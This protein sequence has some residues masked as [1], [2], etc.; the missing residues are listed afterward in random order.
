MSFLNSVLKVFVGDKAK[1]DVK[2]LQPIIDKIHSFEKELANLSNDE[3]RN[4]TLSFKAQLKNDTQVINDRIQALEVEVK[5]S[6][7][8]DKNEDIYAEIDGL[9]KE[10]YEISE[11]TL[12]SILP[13]AFAVVKETS[14]RFAN[15]TT[16]EVTASEY[17]RQLSG[18]K[19]YV[20]LEGDK[21]IWQNSWNAAGKEV[22]WD[23]VH[24]DVQL[25]GG[26]ALHEGKI[27]EMHTGEG[28]TLVAT[29][30]LYLNA[31]TGNGVH[32]VTVN[33]YLAKR[34]SA[35]M[36]PI[37][38]FHG[39][40]IECIDNHQ[41]NS[42]GRRAAYNA[43]ITYGT[44]NEFG[45][46]YLRDNMAHTPSDLVQRPHNFAIVD[47][48]DSVLVDDARTPLIISG[49]VPK[50]DIQEFDQLKPKVNDIVSLQKH[51]LT[52]VLAEAKKLIASGDT[53]EGG[54]QLLR[55]HRGLPKNK[56]LIKFLSEEGVK[57]LLQKT[58]NYYMQDNNRE[59]PKV[60]EELW[61]VIDE[62]NNQIELT[63]KGVEHI[64]GEQDP[65]FFLMPD[66]GGE[67]AKIENQHLDVEKEAE[68]KEELF[69]EFGVKSE[70]I[71][72]LNQ[73]LKAYTLFEKDVEY[74]V[75]EN[76]VMIVDEQT[77]RIMDGRRYSDGLHQAIEAKENVKIE[78]A[79]QTFA[80]VTL[81]NYF[82]MYNKLAGMTGTAITEAG[83]F[84][85]I[86]KLDV[87]EIP[88][89]RPIARDD[90][91]DLIYKTKREKYNA[92][93]DQVTELSAAGRP[94]LIGTTSVEISEL[95]SRMLSIRKVPH[96]VL[97]AKMHKKEADIVEEAGKAGIVTIAT[98]MAGR[99]TDIKLSDAVKKSGGLAIIGTER[100]DSRRVDRQLRG[101]SGRQG[102]PGS[103]Q[104]YVSLEDN[105]MRLFGSDRVAKMMD[106][107]G[108][109]DGE[110]I[111]HSMMT[112][113]IE[114]AQKKVEENNFGVRKR[115]LEY[116]D[117]M[118][119]QREVVYKR[120]RHALQGERLKVDIANMIYD[121]CEVIAETNK[122]ASDYKN[123]EFELIK[124]FAITS[125]LTEEEFSKKSVQEIA[126]LLYKNAYQHYQEKMERSATV[127][128]R[129]IKNVYEDEANKF[130]RIVVPFSD[131][132]KTFNIVT[133]LKE[134][135]ESEGKQL[136]TDFE[137]NI[138]LAIVD[139]AWKVH[140]RKMDELKQSVQLAVHEQK[141]PLLIYKFEAFELFKGMIEKV[142]KEVVA[143]LYKGEIPNGND[144]NIQ[145]AKTISEPK[146][147]LNVSKEEVLNSDELA[148]QNRAVGQNQGSRPP[149][150]E[151]ITREAPKIGRNDR[152]TIKN[153][154]SG[155]SRT[156][157]FKQAEPLLS[158]GEWVI[159]EH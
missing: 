89:N 26:I 159:T 65:T 150:T 20:S 4:K 127:A 126:S 145:E 34:D 116:D 147:N 121:T 152:V 15:N 47:E 25:I 69:K 30:P 85:E 58:E 72:T 134:A 6:K 21:A 135:Y 112:K 84:W 60:D 109:E 115:L 57:Q 123:F 149:I 90:R 27:A 11:K 104:F 117:V 86:Y 93:I 80:T 155:E 106:R 148:A 137:K 82:R 33:D 141:D 136:I 42:D 78:A 94:V 24:Y 105:L 64:S 77:G 158:K 74:V 92:I 37:F 66:I 144:T 29:L 96:N 129:V 132:I 157:K 130:E 142:N 102:D 67:I 87:M 43:D 103:S 114:R 156:V 14:K 3:I 100:H 13:E 76:K 35:W 52:G 79:T 71:H 23:M 45:F 48:V 113:S 59:M 122:N 107:M 55:V 151:T 19:E 61:F 22:T 16:I 75:M 62:K 1:K 12:K 51:Y 138:T 70:R 88:T 40:T 128:N 154:M 120:R 139:D 108:L 143:F 38:Q 49:P 118:N 63:E 44:N 99:G 32:L 36:A 101:R 56:A 41:P 46:D 111:Q 81:Q 7:D 146:E 53:K 153:V 91:N 68:L 83:E 140:L 110:V 50:G 73:L 17:D 98:N 125:P 8:I 28:K 124:Y 133:N 18:T 54:F 95:L 10:A 131:G 2:E 39:I 119:A 9:K 31:L 5:N 97:N